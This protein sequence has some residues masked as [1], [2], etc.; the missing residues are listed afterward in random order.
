VHGS[1]PLTL[2]VFTAHRSE[3]TTTNI[4]TLCNNWNVKNTTAGTILSVPHCNFI[5]APTYRLILSR[6]CSRTAFSRPRP[7]V[8]KAKD[9]GHQGQGWRSSRPRTVVFKAKDR[10][11]RGQGQWSSRPRTEVF[12]AKDIGLRG[13]GQWS[14][15][16]RT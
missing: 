15:R 6:M 1:S 14:S 16:Q 10:G 7:V 2:Y 13:Q 4:N 5:N 8:F 9:K 11:V 3:R 12:K